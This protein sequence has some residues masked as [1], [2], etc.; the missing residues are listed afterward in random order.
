LKYEPKPKKFGNSK[1]KETKTKFEVVEEIEF[2]NENLEVEHSSRQFELEATMF[3]FAALEDNLKIE[4]TTPS[5]VVKPDYY[6]ANEFGESK[7]KSLIG[8]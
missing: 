4:G 8:T 3:D 6:M 7:S 1:N 5:G 2:E